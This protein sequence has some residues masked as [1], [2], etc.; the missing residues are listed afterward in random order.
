MISIL[1]IL[2]EVK[3]EQ[4]V[5]IENWQRKHKN[6]HPSKNGRKDY[7]APR[8]TG[9]GGHRLSIKCIKMRNSEHRKK[10]NK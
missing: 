7:S 1:R 6:S 2:P 8:N 5:K 4:E 9:T 3:G 10:T